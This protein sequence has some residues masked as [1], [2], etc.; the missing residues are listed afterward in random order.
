MA[1]AKVDAS[2]DPWTSLLETGRLWGNCHPDRSAAVIL[3]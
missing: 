2:H 1:K 3:F